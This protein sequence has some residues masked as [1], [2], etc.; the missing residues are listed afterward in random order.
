MYS[1]GFQSITPRKSNSA[2][3]YSSISIHNHTGTLVYSQGFQSI[4][5]H[6]SNSAHVYY[7]HFN[8]QTYRR[9]FISN[10]FPRISIHK[11]L[12]QIHHMCICQ[13]FNLYFHRNEIH[14]MCISQVFKLYFHRNEIHY[15]CISQLFNLYFHRNEI[16]HMCISQYFNPY[17]YFKE[18]LK[19]YLV[20]SVVCISR[21]N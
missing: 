1:Q 7:Q 20:V 21:K 2:H 18:E 4:T 5:P 10:V 9:N 8:L 12:G 19:F 11:P 6:K 3:V 17:V 13:V 16:H 14:F 15:M